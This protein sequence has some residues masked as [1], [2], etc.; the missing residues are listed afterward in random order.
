MKDVPSKRFVPVAPKDL[1]IDAARITIEKKKRLLVFDE[2]KFVGIITVSDMLRGLRTMGGNPDLDDVIRRKVY[3]CLYYD[4]IFKAVKIMHAK[5]VG[6]V[7]VSKDERYH[8][9]FTERDLLT[10]VLVKDAD[11]QDRLEIYQSTP[12]ITA[13]LGIKGDD[14]A[15]IMSKNK[16]KR[17]ALVQRGEVK[18]IVTAR[19]IVDAFRRP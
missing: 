4:S 7:L 6:S 10:R 16:I 1:V 8:G 11:L 15:E 3:G 9:I 12:L 5:K 17:L 2:E 19:D 18:G 13:P 14:A